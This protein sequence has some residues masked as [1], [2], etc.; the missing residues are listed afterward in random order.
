VRSRPSSSAIS[1]SKP[2]SSR[3]RPTSR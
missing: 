3:A 2:S 1:A